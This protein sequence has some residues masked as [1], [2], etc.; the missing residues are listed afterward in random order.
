MSRRATP[1]LRVAAM[2]ATLLSCSSGARGEP[3]P[4]E[5]D[6]PPGPERAAVRVD[7]RGEIAM[8]ASYGPAEVRLVIAS[9]GGER[10]IELGEGPWPRP[11]RITEADLDGLDVGETLELTVI[12]E[13][14]GRYGKRRTL[15]VPVHTT[16]LSITPS[17]VFDLPIPASEIPSEAAVRAMEVRPDEPGSH[18]DLQGVVVFDNRRG[19]PKGNLSVMDAEGVLRIDLKGPSPVAFR[20]QDADVMKGYRIRE[21][22][23]KVHA[24][25]HFGDGRM[26]E[27]ELEV[28]AK[29]SGIV[30]IPTYEP[31]PP[32]PQPTFTARPIDLAGTIRLPKEAGK[33]VRV[34]L[35]LVH[36][37][38]ASQEV[39]LEGDGAS[40]SFHLSGPEWAAVPVMGETVTV[41]ARVRID[42]GEEQVDVQTVP[43]TADG[44]VFTPKPH[45]IS[46]KIKEPVYGNTK[47]SRYDL[48]AGGK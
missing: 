11:F 47:G 3:R 35:N 15:T 30:M 13:V 5:P 23:V 8:D 42:G 32:T 17:E 45:V 29:T 19:T 18:L 43:L 20:L 4:P 27:Q 31:P 38:G 40:R 21:D 46:D 33:D 1:L 28:P 16:S 48:G 24:V 34:S 26:L 39:V 12:A 44:L 9:G 2:G 22:T 14:G 25:V 7:L 41:V 36:P 6:A 37:L 10:V